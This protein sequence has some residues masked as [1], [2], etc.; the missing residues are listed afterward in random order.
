MARYCNNPWGKCPFNSSIKQ[1]LIKGYNS[2]DPSFMKQS[3]TPTAVIKLVF[4]CYLRDDYVMTIKQKFKNVKVILSGQ[5]M[6]PLV[7]ALKYKSIFLV[8]NR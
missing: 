7:I 1:P 8:F 6:K 2:N 3:D 5:E 4:D